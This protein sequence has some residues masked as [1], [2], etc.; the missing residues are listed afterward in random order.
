MRRVKYMG[1]ADVVTIEK[2]DKFGGS[3][4]EGIPETLVWNKQNYWVVE[5]EDDLAELLVA[6]PN[7]RFKDVTDASR[8]P[9]NS[10]QRTFMGAPKT[11]DAPISLQAGDGEGG[12]AEGVSTGGAAAGTTV[13]GS[14]SGGG[15]RGGGSAAGGSTS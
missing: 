11:A 10:H 1:I 4:N 6:Q 8:I 3:L 14:T 9:A 15:R 2:G 12:A 7:N 13:G 5:V